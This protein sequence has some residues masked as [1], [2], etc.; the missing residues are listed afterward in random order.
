[1]NGNTKASSAPPHDLIELTPLTPLWVYGV[2][3]VISLGVVA[4]VGWYL[5]RRHLRNKSY[6]AVVSSDLPGLRVEDP[7]QRL[8]R[9]LS[10]LQ[11]VEPFDAVAQMQYFSALTLYLREAIELRTT[12]RATDMTV[13][14]LHPYLERSPFLEEEERYNVLSFL[15]KADRIKFAG[16]AVSLTEAEAA[17][18]KAMKWAEKWLNA[19]ISSL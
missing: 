5:W 2:A 17:R 18:R 4:A 14:E 13:N 1:M 9:N 6:P 12:I 8:L 15:D 10:L 16:E 11:P 7:R 19:H 3:A